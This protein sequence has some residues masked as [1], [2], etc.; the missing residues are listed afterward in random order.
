MIQKNLNDG[1]NQ[2]NTAYTKSKKINITKLIYACIILI[3]FLTNP[4]NDFLVQQRNNVK[5]IHHQGVK[6][7]LIY[8]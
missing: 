2:W 8:V 4:S 7:V 5:H 3:T 1:N 6:V